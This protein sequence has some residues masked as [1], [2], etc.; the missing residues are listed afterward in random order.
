[1]VKRFAAGRERPADGT[2]QAVPHATRPSVAEAA[3]FSV[4]ASKESMA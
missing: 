3:A 4:G 2:A 1:M